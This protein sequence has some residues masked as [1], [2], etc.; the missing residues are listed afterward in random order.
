MF[1]FKFRKVF[2]IG[3]LGFKVSERIFFW[4]FILRGLGFYLNFFVLGVE[5]VYV[6]VWY[7]MFGD[8][9]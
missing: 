8:N 3:I 5:F 6:Y 2:V 1:Y 7:F 9:Y 4:G